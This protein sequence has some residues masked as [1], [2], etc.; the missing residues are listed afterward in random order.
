VKFFSAQ[1]GKI[2]WS[3]ALS[4]T[5][6][7]QDLGIFSSKNG[8]NFEFLTNFEDKSDTLPLHV[9]ILDLTGS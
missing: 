8:R 5:N 7:E 2:P 3:L 1:S 6:S 4:N 9:V